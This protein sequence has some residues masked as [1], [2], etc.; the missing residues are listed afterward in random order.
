MPP[1]TSTLFTEILRPKSLDQAILTK[2]VRD[3]LTNEINSQYGLI[4]NVLLFGGPGQGKTTLSRI[5]AQGHD[6]KVINCSETGIDAVREDI[7]MFAAQMSLDNPDN[8]IK[9]FFLKSVTDS[10]S[11]LGKQ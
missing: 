4:S 1:V 8:P 5:L 6:T 2:R 11:M 7:Q 9:V 3:Q 10:L